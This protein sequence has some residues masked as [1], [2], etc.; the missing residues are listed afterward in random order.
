MLAEFN[1]LCGRGQAPCTYAFVG[2]VYL[3]YVGGSKQVRVQ[4]RL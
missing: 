3:C 2:S 4:H 1:I